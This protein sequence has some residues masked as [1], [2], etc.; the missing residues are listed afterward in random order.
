MA[1][2][3]QVAASLTGYIG[4]PATVY[5]A[6]GNTQ[7][8]QFNAE[9]STQVIYRTAGTLSKLWVFVTP[10]P[11]TGAATVKIRKNG[12]DGNMSVS[13]P[14]NTSGIFEDNSNTDT[15]AAGDTLDYAVTCA[16]GVQAVTIAAINTLFAAD[17]IGGIDY[18]VVRHVAIGTVALASTVTRNSPL[19]GPGTAAAATEIQCKFDVNTACTLKNLYVYVVNNVLTGASTF[20]VRINGGNSANLVISVPGSTSGA[21]EDTSGARAASVS[22]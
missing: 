21:F 1:E 22:F 3:L 15:V 4:G 9:A 6:C 7:L 13:I 19:A 14:A 10:N 20:R 5:T 11:P 16:A 12:A 17:T 2:A 18:T 8:L